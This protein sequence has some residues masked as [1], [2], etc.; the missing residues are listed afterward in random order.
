MTGWNEGDVI[1][2]RLITHESTV[3][4]AELRRTVRTLRQ[5]GCPWSVIGDALGTTRQAAQM[6]YGK[7]ATRDDAAQ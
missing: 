6:R 4:D 1:S 2:L 3:L 5:D 7:I